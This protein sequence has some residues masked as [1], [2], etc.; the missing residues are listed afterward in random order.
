M[1]LLVKTVTPLEFEEFWAHWSLT[2][3]AALPWT[4]IA[5]IRM[6]EGELPTTP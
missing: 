2:V 5:R 1:K 3:P 6:N 4:T